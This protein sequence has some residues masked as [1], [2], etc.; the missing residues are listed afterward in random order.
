M[1]I[2]GRFPGW[3]SR[4]QLGPSRLSALR[5]G[6]GHRLLKLGLLSR[7][8][9]AK[10]TNALTWRFVTPPVSKASKNELRLLCAVPRFVGLVFYSRHQRP[11]NNQTVSSQPLPITE[12][13]KSPLFVLRVYI[14]QN[15]HINLIHLTVGWRSVSF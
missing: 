11:Y 5:P 15:R 6:G 14:K 2:K 12:L 9:A 3:T 4:A 7:S 8:A 13:H 10:V 1:A